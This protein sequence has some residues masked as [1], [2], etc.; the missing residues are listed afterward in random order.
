LGDEIEF[1][2]CLKDLYD[3]GMNV[4]LEC[5]PRLVA[6]YQ[7]LYP[8]FVVRCESVDSKNYPLFNDFDVE[9]PL[10]SLPRLL[11][12]ILKILKNNFAFGFQIILEFWMQKKN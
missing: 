11:G 2:T 1:S 9:Y 4:I 7:R 5:D 10:G 3:A 12:V 8:N 6:I